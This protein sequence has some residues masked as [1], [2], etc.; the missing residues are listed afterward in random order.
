MVSEPSPT[1]ADSVFRA[2]LGAGVLNEQVFALYDTTKREFLADRRRY[3]LQRAAILV[4]EDRWLE[5]PLCMLVYGFG[6][7]WS[8]VMTINS[9]GVAAHHDSVGY[10]A[11]GGGPERQIRV[12]E[13]SRERGRWLKDVPDAILDV[14]D[15]KFRVEG[16]GIGRLTTVTILRPDDEYFLDSVA[17]EELHLFW[18]STHKPL[19]GTDR[20]W[21]RRVCVKR[22]IESAT[23]YNQTTGRMGEE[24]T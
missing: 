4:R 6:R 12:L 23:S 13:S 19:Q 9:P 2:N 8:H 14:C 21:G 7:D 5:I 1:S 20:E 11:I 3:K 24:K 16:N 15:A 10:W 18:D 17:I 22:A